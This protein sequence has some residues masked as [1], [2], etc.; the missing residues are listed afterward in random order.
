MT[1]KSQH[2]NPRLH[3]QHFAGTDPK[4]QV[5]TY[6]AV[7]GKI[8]SAIPDETAVQTHFYSAEKDDGTKDTRLEELLSKV[9]SNAAPIYRELLNGNIPKESQGRVDFAQ[10]LAIMHVRTPAMRRMAGELIGRSA[11][12]LQYA[13]ASNPKSFDA[14]T[15]QVEAE[16]GEAMDPAIKEKVRQA[17]LDPSG[18]GYELEVAKEATFMALAASD[19]L[20]PLIHE[21]KWTVIEA[22]DGY[23]VTSDNPV[24]REVDPKTH[25]PIYG[26]H[27]FRNKTAEVTFPLSPKALL[28]LTWDENVPEHCALQGGHV[29]SMNEVRAGHSDRYLYAHVRDSR[30]EQL[31]AKH[32]DSRPNV[33]TDGFGPEKFAPVKVGRR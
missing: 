1:P 29:D 17:M 8:W 28:L 16:K 5:W 32:K 26:D 31:A 9:E 10:F 7:N 27:G 14:L 24:V 22:Q 3:L 6:D 21:M 4:G 15:K 20:T 25:H 23:F 33:T 18:S 13:Y 12:I 11:Q 2:F 19:K 30:L